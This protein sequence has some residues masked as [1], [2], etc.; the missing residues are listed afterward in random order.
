MKIIDLIWTEFLLEN[1]EKV[2]KK[3]LE[4]IKKQ[5]II[6]SS[7]EVIEVINIDLTWV[8]SITYDFIRNF[9]KFFINK[10]V[11]LTFDFENEKVEK[12]F[13]KIFEEM[14]K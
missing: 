10:N 9:L 8:K 7:L 3:V 2:A 14:R 13:N 1:W 6:T 4:N 12:K 11:N 5:V